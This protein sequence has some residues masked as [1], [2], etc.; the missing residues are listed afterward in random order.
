MIY[1]HFIHT[2]KEVIDRLPVV[3]PAKSRKVINF[4]RQ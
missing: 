1:S 4:L 3:V 2:L